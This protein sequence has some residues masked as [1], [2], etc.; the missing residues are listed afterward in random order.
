MNQREEAEGLFRSCLP[1]VL[2]E[3]SEP[4]F[5]EPWQALVFAMTINLYDRGLF[6]WSEWTDV[7]ARILARR[8]SSGEDHGGRFYYEDWLTALETVVSK[9]T[10][11]QPAILSDLKDRWERAYRA[12]PHGEKVTL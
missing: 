5:A 9:Q 8:A 4:V 12:T 7:F 6:S 3:G 11:I 1:D 10:D 2:T